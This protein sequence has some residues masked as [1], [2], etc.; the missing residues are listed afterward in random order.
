MRCCPNHVKAMHVNHTP[1]NHLN[2][3]SKDLGDFLEW[4]ICEPF[5]Q[6][7]PKQKRCVN[8]RNLGR[9]NPAYLFGTLI[10]KLDVVV[11]GI[12]AGLSDRW[13]VTDF[14]VTHPRWQARPERWIF[15]AVF[16]EGLREEGLI[17][18]W[19]RRCMKGGGRKRCVDVSFIVDND[20]EIGTKLHD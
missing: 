16:G 17:G 15:R 13:P 8:N 11:T 18:G 12:M 14:P 20:W 4:P 5:S 9:A 1:T 10:R 3:S 2:Q 7:I 19:V 6:T